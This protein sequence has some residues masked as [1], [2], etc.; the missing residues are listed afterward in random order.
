VFPGVGVGPREPL[1]RQMR[2]GHP[3]VDGRPSF[4]VFVRSFS[5][6]A[7]CS[8]GQLRVSASAS[9]RRPAL[10]RLEIALRRA[11]QLALRSG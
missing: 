1:Q 8:S 11:E 3:S 4:A 7:R 5:A 6:V 9:F 10:V 2:K